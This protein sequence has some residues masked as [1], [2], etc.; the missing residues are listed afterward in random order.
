MRIVVQ[1][2]K[3]A[4]VEVEGDIVGQIGRG[5]LVYA[6]VGEDD[7]GE[8]VRFIA[9][10]IV[11][12]RIFEDDAGKMNLSVSDVGG[13]ILLVSNFTLHGD[14]RKGRRPGFDAAAGPVKA[15]ELFDQ[16]AELVKES[17]LK[18]ET[19][20]FGAHMHVD[21]VNDGPINFLLSSKKV[22]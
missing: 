6:S 10:R 22:F 9:E 11:N 2:V 16:L 18:V 8:D 19:G 5:L 21:S 20:V 7:T 17:R 4:C 14:C 13:E 3:R 1:R 15:N 12:L